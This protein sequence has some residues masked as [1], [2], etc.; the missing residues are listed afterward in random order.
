MSLQCW[1]ILDFCFSLASRFNQWAFWLLSTWVNSLALFL[2][3]LSGL[4]SKVLLLLESSLLLTDLIELTGKSINWS[5][6][7][8]FELQLHCDILSIMASSWLYELWSRISLLWWLCIM[9][10]QGSCRCMR[11]GSTWDRPVDVLAR[12]ILVLREVP[13]DTLSFWDVV[14]RLWYELLLLKNVLWTEFVRW[15]FLNGELS[16]GIDQVVLVLEAMLNVEV[17]AYDAVWCSIGGSW[18][19]LVSLANGL[20]WNFM[21][22]ASRCIKFLCCSNVLSHLLF[23][24]PRCNFNFFVITWCWAVLTAGWNFGR[25]GYHVGAFC[26]TLNENLILLVFELL[27]TV[28][29]FSDFLRGVMIIV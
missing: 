26:T 24:L 2:L 3:L 1:T 19:F 17:T 25:I 27:Q 22:V 28:R 21:K 7:R 11:S 12:Q 23:L 13:V 20:C 15:T 6:V 8:R 18:H 29:L 10:S 14:Q 9:D 16:M 4:D 5:W